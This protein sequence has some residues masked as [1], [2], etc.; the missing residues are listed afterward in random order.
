MI[1]DL[2]AA[3][4]Y[5]CDFRGHFYDKYELMRVGCAHFYLGIH[6]S[7]SDF[8]FILQERYIRWERGGGGANR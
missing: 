6:I 2:P 3:K 1:S 5:C 7:F 8:D 4:T